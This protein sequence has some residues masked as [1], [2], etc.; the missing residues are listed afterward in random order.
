MNLFTLGYRK[1]LVQKTT[2]PDFLKPDNLC[3][4][5]GGNFDTTKLKSI[6][7]SFFMYIQNKCL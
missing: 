5:F 6:G 2:G 3:A 4:Y 7:R 1:R